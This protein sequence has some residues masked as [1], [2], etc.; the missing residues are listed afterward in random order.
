MKYVWCIISNFSPPPSS[1]PLALL[2]LYDV[3]NKNSFDNTRA[4]LAEVHEYAQDDVVIMLIGEK[5]SLY[6]TTLNDSTLKYTNT[7][8][9]VAIALGSEV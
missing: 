1:V 4:W 5:L 3:M 6:C 2:L 9:H 8:L 7:T